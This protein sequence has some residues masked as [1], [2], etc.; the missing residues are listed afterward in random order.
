MIRPFLMASMITAT[1]AT[2]SLA[3]DCVASSSAEIG[4]IEIV[5][6]RLA[7]GVS[8]D[9]FVTAA[10]NTMPALCKTEGFIG[11]ILSEGKDGTWI[12]Y[13]KW[14]NPALA[15]AAMAGSMEN[16]ALMPFIMSVDPDS[17]VLTYQTPVD[18]N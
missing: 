4:V 9:K 11:R 17:I 12:D 13:V 7:E 14:T 15:K 1:F 18:L 8:R 16:A 5:Q 6:F 10:A 2:S 3:Q